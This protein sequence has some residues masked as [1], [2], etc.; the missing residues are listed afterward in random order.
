MLQA[1]GIL[2]VAAVLGP[3][4]GL[5]VSGLPVLGPDRAQESRG[6]E[7]ARAHLHVVRLQQ[8]A[9]APIPVLVELEDD[10]LKSQHRPLVTLEYYRVWSSGGTRGTGSG[11]PAGCYQHKTK[12][13]RRVV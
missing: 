7:R 1:V 9:A 12:R 3:A 2:A 11:Q 10:L 4:R 8:H 6:V 13:E 5:N